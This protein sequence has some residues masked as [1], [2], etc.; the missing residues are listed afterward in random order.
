MT[1]KQLK[2]TIKAI[3][4]YKSPKWDKLYKLWDL[5]FVEKANLNSIHLQNSAI[6]FCNFKKTKNVIHLIL[7]RPKLQENDGHF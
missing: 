7:I 4:L 2:T 6:F 1:I 5:S 3:Q